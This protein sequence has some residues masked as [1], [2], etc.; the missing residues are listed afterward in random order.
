[1]WLS[2]D[3]VWWQN[4]LDHPR[5]QLRLRGRTVEGEARV[6]EDESDA[7]RALRRLVKVI[8]SY[9]RPAHLERTDGRVPDDELVR[10]VRGD[11][12]CIR[13]VLDPPTKEND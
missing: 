11:R 13:V 10:A 4:L 5:V 3:S 7:V 9:S 6:I 12:T 8:P 2:T 1:M